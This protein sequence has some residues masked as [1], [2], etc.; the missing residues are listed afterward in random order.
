MASSTL[1]TFVLSSC[2]ALAVLTAPQAAAL[3]QTQDDG[4]LWLQSVNQGKFGEKD[5][6]LAKWRWWLEAQGRWR[7]NG[8]TFDTAFL[9]SGFG[10]AI[11]DRVV[12]HIGY[13][14]FDTE[15]DNKPVVHENRIW[16]Q[17]VW[18]APVEGFTFQSRTR[19][20]ERF[21]ADQSDEGWRLRQFFKSTI[22]VVED[23]T[24]F[25]SVWDEM[26]W[27]LS[28]T[29]WGQRTGFRQNRAFLGLGQFLDEQKSMSIE[30]GY[31]NQWIDRT[32]EDRLN[33]I[34][35]ICFFV[36]F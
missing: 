33:H 30:V 36:N 32:D 34:L 7:D 10:Y 28:D 31:L 8:G 26:F 9:R 12:A 17:L 24:T 3:A 18:N 14:F 22:P 4:A 16:Q 2:L 27:D 1:R 21:V 29:D 11:T 25:V 5:S 19:L 23:K 6:P 15:P 35:L 13:A 20:E